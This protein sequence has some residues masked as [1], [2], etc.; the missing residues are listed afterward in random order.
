M[1]RRFNRAWNWSVARGGPGL[2]ASPLT[3]LSCKYEQRRDKS[4]V[5]LVPLSQQEVVRFDVGV[6]DVDPVQQL[7]HVEDADGE[8]HDEGLRHH[9][10]TEGSVH[11]HSVLQVE[12]QHYSETEKL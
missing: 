10:V 2:P 1:T 6:D 11:V 5:W 12:Q 3:L 4:S 8:V 9:F 7:H